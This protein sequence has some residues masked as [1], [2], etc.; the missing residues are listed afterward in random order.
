[1]HTRV[2]RLAAPLALLT[3]LCLA[4]AGC[5]TQRA[6]E[7]GDVDAPAARSARPAHPVPS[8]HPMRLP[9]ADAPFDYQLGG[10]YQ[11]PAGVRAVSRDRSA[12]PAPGLYNVCYVNAF[13]AQ[14]G[15]AVDWWRA[16]HPGLLL[17]DRRGALVIDEDWHEPLLDISTAGKRGELMDVVG[18]W[19]DGCAKAGFDAVEPDNLDSYQRSDGLLDEADAVAFAKLLV[20]RGHHDGLAVAQKNTGE[21]LGRHKQIGFDFAVVEECA[22]YG[23]CPD[24]AAAY[25]RRIFDIEYDGKDFSAACRRFG[26]TLS[27]TLRDRDVL[28]AGAPG[29]RDERC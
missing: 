25:D 19:L 11:P 4:A 22:H 6:A 27:V 10:A 3:A 12:R 16:H 20:R 7:P 15:D 14:P 24:F 23:E 28:P 18:G 29:H 2:R 13:Q 8:A 21:L 26:R 1:M 17:R 5:S 9:A